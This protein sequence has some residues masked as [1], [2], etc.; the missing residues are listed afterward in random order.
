M[1]KGLR[2]LFDRQQCLIML[3]CHSKY[4]TVVKLRATKG[5]SN[6]SVESLSVPHSFPSSKQLVDLSVI[7]AVSRVHTRWILMRRDVFEWSRRLGY[8]VFV[9]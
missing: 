7:A 3:C 2:C 9:C 8:F 5:Q 6:R 1:K 4:L